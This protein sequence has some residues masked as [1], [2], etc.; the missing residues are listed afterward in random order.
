VK[1]PRRCE[2]DD[3]QIAYS[4][5]PSQLQPEDFE[6]DEPA[7]EEAALKSELKI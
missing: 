5:K 6:V 1:P 4:P 2:L 7:G 3:R